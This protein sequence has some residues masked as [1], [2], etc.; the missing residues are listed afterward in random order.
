MKIFISHSSKENNILVIPLVELLKEKGYDIW[1][2]IKDMKWDSSVVGKISEGL[3]ECDQY[4]IIIS[5]D[6][7]KSNYCKMEYKS[8]IQVTRKL[9]KGIF[10][11]RVDNANIPILLLDHYWIDFNSQ[12]SEAERDKFFLNIIEKLKECSKPKFIDE[13]QPLMSKDIVELILD[14]NKKGRYGLNLLK[15]DIKRSDIFPQ[16]E[17][18]LLIKPGGTFHPPALLEIFKRC[19]KYCNVR[20]IRVYN[21]N[22]IDEFGL[23]DRQYKPS[24]DISKGIIELDENELGTI[25]LIYGTPD[26]ERKYGVKFTEDLI[27]PAFKL[28]EVF[29][30]NEDLLSNKWENGRKTNFRTGTYDG[31]N[32]VG[33][34]KTIFPIMFEKIP[35]PNVFLVIN[36]WI[37]SYKKLFTNP[38]A[39]VIAIHVSA[40]NQEWEVIREELVGGDSD[41]EKCR[42]GSIRYDAF[43]KK[44]PLDPKDSLVNGQRN[45][46]H[47]SATHCD[48]MRELG[49][50]FNYSYEKTSLGKLIESFYQSPSDLISNMDS[51]I[52]EVSKNTRDLN[53]F[54]SI[55]EFYHRILRKIL[56][57]T[58]SQFINKFKYYA[59]KTNVSINELMHKEQ[60]QHLYNFNLNGL[61]LEFGSEL[62]F[63]E[64]IANIFDVNDYRQLFYEISDQI[65]ELI[66]KNNEKIDYDV[67]AESYRIAANDLKFLNLPIYQSEEI[68]RPKLLRS[69][70]ESELAKCALDCAKRT[71]LNI[72]KKARA[73]S[74]ARESDDFKTIEKNPNWN[75]F[76]KRN[77]PIK[78]VEEEK[79]EYLGIILSGGRSTRMLSTIPKPILP[80]YNHLLFNK[81]LN[82]IME[83]TNNICSIFAAVGYRANAIKLAIGDN[84]KYLDY[85]GKHGLGFRVA[86][87]LESLKLYD[88]LIIL[89]CV[90][91]P[92]ISPS[93][94]E[95]L[96]KLVKNGGKKTF[97]LLISRTDKLSG[98]IVLNKNGKITKVIQER[99]DPEKVESKMPRDAGIYIFYNTANLRKILTQIKNDN[100]RNEYIFADIIEL[101]HK[102]GW[103]I[104]YIEEDPNL[105][106]GIDTPNDLLLISSGLTKLEAENFDLNLQTIKEKLKIYYNLEVTGFKNL[107]RFK[108]AIRAF[109]GPFYFFDYWDNYWSTNR[110]L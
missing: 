34:Q 29:N 84:V 16:N 14:A 19:L 26:F 101:L 107:K 83:A 104:E 53:I 110:E 47:C 56:S 38:D 50:W 66:T 39:R 31:M 72:I 55:E 94:I 37:P 90:D 6:Y 102:K 49:I 12:F 10:L 78:T 2:D 100:I 77:I 24:I 81:T 3:E 73:I 15:K 105:A 70:L 17:G 18:V 7:L 45:V 71:K 61:R 85:A 67:L 95:K 74:K 79:I 80:I 23:F 25:R 52:Q 42:P 86:T 43:H 97:G 98:H 41:P 75:N 36:G 30:I 57:G 63:L 96:I 4:M 64:T 88:G 92:L 109:F 40:I 27:I 33:Y 58:K 22:M 91:M 62:F 87:C 68:Y 13:Y 93:N 9:E 89:C 8:I 99:L 65:K 21:G 35:Q 106:Y 59:E 54:Q 76:I 46:C 103:N 69:K 11:I 82:L 32:K 20:Q 48:G 108:E 44:I 5:A 60:F 51:I 28:C 1:V